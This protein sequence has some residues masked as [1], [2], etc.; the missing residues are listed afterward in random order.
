[1]TRAS[2]NAGRQRIE[3]IPEPLP[4]VSSPPPTSTRP[5]LARTR[6]SSSSSVTMG[7]AV[8]AAGIRVDV[9]V[10]RAE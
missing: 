10:M 5:S 6:P 7:D 8:S 2:R 4:D 1:M 9:T 3:E